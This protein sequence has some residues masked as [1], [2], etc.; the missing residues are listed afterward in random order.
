[1]SGVG[2]MF[3]IR[4]FDEMIGYLYNYWIKFSYLSD[5]YF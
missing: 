5:D 1:M 2:S 4:L 3:R